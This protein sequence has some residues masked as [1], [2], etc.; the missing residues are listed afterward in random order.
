MLLQVSDIRKRYVLGGEDIEVLRGVDL[1]VTSGDFLSIMGTSGSGKSTLLHV[2]GGLTLPDSG[3]YLF[4]DRNM[5]ALTDNELSWIRAH[6]L[7]FVFQTF[8][9]LPELDVLG[10]VSLPFLYNRTDRS[11]AQRKVNEAIERVG[12]GHRKKHRPAELSG[13]EMQRV[14]IARALAISPKL[15]LADEPTGNLDTRSSLAILELFQELNERGATIVMV[16]H[17]SQVAAVSKKIIKMQ[18]GVLLTD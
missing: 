10:N 4:S 3:T 17:D 12:L 11:D 5:L 1:T 8:D 15:I 16:T 2:L 18:D 6:W 13:G 14:A 9:L 7:G